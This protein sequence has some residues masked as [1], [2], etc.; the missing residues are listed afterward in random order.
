MSGPATTAPATTAPSTTT[1]ATAAQA[2]RAP[3]P[4]RPLGRPRRWMPLTVLVLGLTSVALLVAVGR[5][6]DQ[7][8]SRDLHT[9]HALADV[10][11]AVTAV[12]L[13]MS[14][15]LAGEDLDV[16]AMTDELEDARQL[17]RGLVEGAPPGLTRTGLEPMRDYGLAARLAELRIL[18]ERFSLLV[19]RQRQAFDAGERLA[20]GSPTVR[21][22]DHVF[23]LFDDS[24]AALQIDMANRILANKRHSQWVLAGILVGWLLIIAG[25]AA[26]LWNHETRSAQAEATLRERDGQL[27]QAQKMEAVGRLAGGIAHDINNYLAAIRGQCELV[28]MKTAA[29]DPAQRRMDL[30]LATSDRA[31]ALIQRLLSFSR[32]QPVERRVV[33]LNAV[34]GNLEPMMERLIGADLHLTVVP[35]HQRC[36]VLVDPTQIEQV[37]VN[38]LIN[39]REAMPTGGEVRLTSSC[40]TLAAGDARRPA[41]LPLGDYVE[42]TVTDTG[43]GISADQLSRIFEPFYT[44]KSEASG[45]GLPTVYGIVQ[46]NGGAVEVESE[47][48]RGSVF[49]ILLPRHREAQPPVFLLPEASAAVP[50]GHGERLL[51]VDDHEEFRTSAVGLLEGLGYQVTAAADAAS[52]EHLFTAGEAPFDLV[53]TDVVMP[54]SNGRQLIERLERRHGAQRSLF[55][56]GYTGDVMQRHGIRE[57]GVALLQKPFAFEVLA[58]KVRELLDAPLDAAKP[59][60]PTP[61]QRRRAHK[62]SI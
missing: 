14:D 51:V 17:S 49:S 10:E 8:T 57:Q 39:A 37:I 19:H 33:D 22:Y 32:R 47:P 21:E 46:Q 35:C 29:D 5:L 24:A 59:A 7:W 44:T 20:A 4:M 26:A 15:L 45:L 60:P 52:A 61:A 30:V 1:Q 42:L 27:L 34:V 36:P 48:G 9:L 62:L 13:Q 43:R 12:H 38:L 23:E 53:I 11:N 58:R 18:V 54:G 40:R 55:V 41:T 56:S 3:A 50:R 28:K 6:S 31:S 16:D 2:T 25:T